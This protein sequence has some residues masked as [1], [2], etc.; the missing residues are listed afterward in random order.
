MYLGPAP[1]NETPA[2]IRAARILGADGGHVHGPRGD[3]GQPLRHGGPGLQ[4]DDQYGSR[5]SGPALTEKE[6][7]TPLRPAKN[8]FPPD[9]QL[10]TTDVTAA[11]RRGKE[12]PMPSIKLFAGTDFTIV[13]MI[14]GTM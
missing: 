6:V 4:P 13:T 9:P 8:V 5:H 10:L 3:C 12:S 14:T 11:L 2:E 1:S 7:P